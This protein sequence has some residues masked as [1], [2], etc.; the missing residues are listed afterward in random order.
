MVELNDIDINSASTKNLRTTPTTEIELQERQSSSTRM[1][2]NTCEELETD[3]KG[4]EG[5]GETEGGEVLPLNETDRS[6]GDRSE[7][8]SCILKGNSSDLLK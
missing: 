6:A 7:V 2:S 1:V 3:S 8:E 4:D 5:G